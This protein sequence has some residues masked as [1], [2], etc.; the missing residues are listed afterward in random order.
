M[1]NKLI[2]L[3]Q[4]FTPLWILLLLTLFMVVVKYPSESTIIS[5]R[6]YQILVNPFARAGK[7]VTDGVKT[8]WNHYLYLVST[9]SENEQLWVQ[10]KQYEGLATELQQLKDENERLRSML[11]LLPRIAY[12]LKTAEI[13]SFDLSLERR[14]F[15][16]NTGTRD[17][18]FERQPVI[19]HNGVVGQ[20][21]KVTPSKS[22]VLTLEDP[23]FHL[24]VMNQRTQERGV[25]TGQQQGHKILLRFA[26]R[27]TDMQVGDKIVT[28]G[29]GGVFPAGLGVG[30]VDEV[31]KPESGLESQIWVV[32]TV[33]FKRIREVF[34]V[35]SQRPAEE[36]P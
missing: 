17:E 9:Q 12:A 18:V 2:K 36:L 5:Y 35:Q 6:L 26:H 24:H 1:V 11:G 27:E 10:V 14:G 32:P 4:Q 19:S 28:S 8:L 21:F 31:L 3:L 16:I 20:I 30:R 15:W 25:V 13:I 34:V 29:L 23:L 7:E 22:L 33:D